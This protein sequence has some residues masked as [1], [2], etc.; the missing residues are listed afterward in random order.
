MVSPTVSVLPGSHAEIQAVPTLD[1]ETTRQSW[2][3]IRVSERESQILELLCRGLPDKEIASMLRMSMGTL[4]THISR[5]FRKTGQRCRTG[6]VG[7]YVA[8]RAEHGLGSGTETI[9][10]NATVR[11]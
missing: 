9:E 11:L 4:R 5:L 7:A 1:G 10:S 6:L 2:S 3:L 8:H